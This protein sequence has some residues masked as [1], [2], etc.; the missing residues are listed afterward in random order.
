M[1]SRLDSRKIKPNSSKEER[2]Y[3]QAETGVHKEG[4]LTNQSMG[5]TGEVPPMV[6]MEEE[7][8]SLWNEVAEKD[9]HG[10]D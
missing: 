10:Q 8:E 1:L 4:A 6:H 7:E 3:D 2:Y 5:T 9:N